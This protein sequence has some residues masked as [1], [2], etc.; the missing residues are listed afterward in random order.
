MMSECDVCK[1][2]YSDLLAHNK[3]YHSTNYTRE[4]MKIVED[5]CLDLIRY[6]DGSYVAAI[7]NSV[8]NRTKNLREKMEAEYDLND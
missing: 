4:L 6:K 5:G 7:A 3:K 1:L 8:L 2:V